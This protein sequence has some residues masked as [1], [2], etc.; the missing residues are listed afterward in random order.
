MQNPADKSGVANPLERK[1]VVNSMLLLGLLL[2][3]LIVRKKR[4]KVKVEIDV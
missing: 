4:T 3:L 1:R 2:I